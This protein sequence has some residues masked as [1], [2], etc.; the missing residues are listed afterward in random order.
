MPPFLR[1]GRWLLAAGLLVAALP[2]QAADFDKYL[3]DDTDAVLTI[4]VKQAVGSA[5]YGKHL[6]QQADALMQLDPVQQ[7]LK[8]TNFDPFKDIER[9]TVITG[10]SS[11][12]PAGNVTDA[13]RRN[14]GFP[15]IVIQGNLDAAK[16]K[17]LANN[18][19]QAAP[20]A[21]ISETKFGN[22]PA[23]EV[24]SGGESAYF[25][26]TEK[27]TLVVT[28][29]K[30]RA[31]A[32]AGRGAAMMKPQLKSKAMQD[33]LARMDPKATASWAA[34]GD[35]IVDTNYDFEKKSMS[36]RTLADQGITAVSGSVTVT[37]SI[38]G[39]AV[40]VC[41]EADKARDLAKQTEAGLQKGIMEMSK[42]AEKDKSLQ[43]LADALKGVKVSTQGTTFTVRG[44]AK[45]E[46]IQAFVNMILLFTGK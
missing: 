45:P 40:L 29:S 31:T 44:E 30:D 37:A 14:A 22:A 5:A 12:P 35:M 21:K 10:K 33:L 11:Y 43:P 26:L 16:V 7:V 1:L 41:K 36:Y 20:N 15:L 9:V 2:A 27:G 42:I 4:N 17:A 3:L 19:G 38:Q 6:K 28:T 39:E 34:T 25:V 13:Q 32:A 24:N 23:W 46:A 8:G 18:I